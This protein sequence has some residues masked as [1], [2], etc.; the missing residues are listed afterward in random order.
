M[1]KIRDTA[2]E[3]TGTTQNDSRLATYR[4][5]AGRYDELI[6]DDG[7]IRSH[8]R[9]LIRGVSEDD[10]RAARR[11]TEFTRRMIVE[12]GVTYN[13]YAD[14]QGRD[15][16]WILDPLPYLVT[17]QEWQSHRGRGRPA[18][19]PV[20]RGALGSLRQ[21]RTPVEGCAARRD[22]VR[23]PEFPVALPRH[24]SCATID[25][26]GS[27]AST[28]RAPPTVAGG[29]SPTAPRRPRARVMR[30]RIARSC[31][32]PCRNW[33]NRWMCGRWARSSPRCATNCCAARARIRSRW[34]SRRARSTRPISSTPT[35]RASSA[36]PWSKD[37][38]SPCATKP[39]S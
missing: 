31:G 23:P 30:S 32:A 14:E 26:C 4:S 9:A 38:T 8:W 37:T 12:N 2:G 35:S 6:A 21:A 19:A 3:R 17:A 24:P 18:R 15:R 29:C 7:G 20:E 5:Y 16:P 25:G 22:P 27:T 36:S 34:C 28:S 10:A 1:E 13:V 11:A 33:R 39:C